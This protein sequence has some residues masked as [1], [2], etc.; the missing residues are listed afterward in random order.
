MLVVVN[1]WT[2]RVHSIFPL[3][4]ATTPPRFVFSSSILQY[5]IHTNIA[6]TCENILH[7]HSTVIS[8][9]FLTIKWLGHATAHLRV[10]LFPGGVDLTIPRDKRR[11]TATTA[12]VFTELRTKTPALSQEQA[13]MALPTPCAIDTS[14]PY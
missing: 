9:T 14:S 3:Q 5:S 10:R 6:I 8:P 7:T 2:T 13:L 4:D 12:V 1:P 11:V